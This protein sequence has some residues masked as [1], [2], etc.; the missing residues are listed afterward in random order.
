MSSLDSNKI[1]NFNPDV[2]VNTILEEAP[3][4]VKSNFEEV[5]EKVSEVITEDIPQVMSTIWDFAVDKAK[6]AYELGVKVY[7]KVAPVIVEAATNVKNAVVSGYEKEGGGIEGI[8]GSANAVAN[9]LGDTLNSAAEY[10]PTNTALGQALKGIVNIL[11]DATKKYQDGITE[12][13]FGSNMQKSWEGFSEYFSKNKSDFNV[14]FSGSNPM[15]PGSEREALY[16]SLILGTPYQFG[17]LADPHNRTLINSL[18]KDSRYLSLTPGMPKYHGSAYLQASSENIFEQTKTPIDQLNYLL[19]NGLD[20][21]FSSKDKRYYTFEAKYSEYFAYLEAMLTPIYIKLGLATDQTSEKKFN[22]FTFFNE[23]GSGTL[24]SQYNS[25]IGFYVNPASAVSES[26]DSTQTSAGSELA[27]R[28]NAMADHYQKINYI[29]GMGTGGAA[30]DTARTIGIGF[31]TAEGIGS[32]LSENLTMASKLSGAISGHLS[33]IP[34]VIGAIAGYA[35][36][37]AIDVARL[38]STEDFGSLIQSFATTNG[39][40]VVYPELWSDTT[41]SKNINFNLSFTSPYGDPMSIFKYVYVPFCALACFALPRQAAENGYVS[42]FFVRADVPGVVTSDLGLISS[43]TWTKGGSNN[44]WTKD[45]LPRSIDVTITI[46]DL[47]PY[48]SMTKRYSF[49]SSNPSYT[50]FLDNMAGMCAL[51]DTDSED[52]LNGYFDELINRVNGTRETTGLWNKFNPSKRANNKDSI[53]G[54]TSIS[55]TTDYIGVPWLH[56]SSSSL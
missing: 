39:M 17:E 56:N 10:I 6:D 5:T 38:S 13:T 4:T 3:T 32:Y 49:L 22:L 48:L 50:V 36:G 47:Y 33:G 45:G 12:T 27:S 7:N 23:N 15:D 28:T 2:S 31:K 19:R 11:G 35:A 52:Y 14:N 29:T 30:R 37:A 40:K 24:K 43:F 16:G 54:K 42:P 53:G 34:K 46:T 21:T 25:S 55:N 26:V 20:Q 44:L 8:F 51:A 1:K 18:I 41:Y 9:L